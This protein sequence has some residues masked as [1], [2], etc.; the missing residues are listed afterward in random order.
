MYVAQCHAGFPMPLK[1][2]KFE[3]YGVR[4]SISDTTAATRLTLV[5][6]QDLPEGSRF[7]NIY[8]TSEV[9]SKKCAFVDERT[10]ASTVGSIDV[11]FPEAIKMRNGVSMAGSNLIGG[12]VTLL[13]R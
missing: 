10:V 6:D 8:S 4:A 9:G 11:M 3:I 12:T 5:D 7:G 13:I 2:G 1:A